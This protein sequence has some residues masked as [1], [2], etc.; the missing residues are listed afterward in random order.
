MDGKIPMRKTIAL[1]F[2]AIFA[3]SM[4]S[5]C[6]TDDNKNTND[7]GDNF[8]FATLDNK[9]EHLSDYRGKVVILDMMAT[10]CQPCQY[11]ML[12][13]RKIYS[14][15]SD[16]DLE[17]ISIDIDTQE[18]AQQ[19]ENYRNTFASY[20]YNLDWT[21]GMDDGSIASKYL[22][23]GIPTLCIF[24]QQGNLSFKH[25]GIS[26]YSSIPSGLSSDTPVLKSI[27]DVLL[28]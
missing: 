9:Q 6:I 8:T 17:I 13:L 22:G 16:N 3:S 1:L 28:S 2:L 15:Y 19:L 12:E 27:I 4:F 24:D 7:T 5:G 18:T 14:N 21:F 20:G 23:Q 26:V 25:E 10:W 11:Q